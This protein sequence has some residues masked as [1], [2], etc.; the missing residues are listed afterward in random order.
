MN[1]NH[2]LILFQYVLCIYQYI[3]LSILGKILQIEIII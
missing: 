2:N 1:Y 3:V